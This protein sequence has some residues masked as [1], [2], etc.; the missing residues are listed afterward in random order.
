MIYDL[1]IQ[2]AHV[3]DP[4]T[5]RN[6]RYHILIQDGKIAKV[7][8]ATHADEQLPEAKQLI[9]AK[10]MIVTPGLIDLHVHVYEDK[11]PLGISADRIGVNQGVTTVVDAGSAG[12]TTFDEFIKIAIEPSTT[13]VLAWIN[14]SGSGLCQGLS[15][16]ANM[17]WLAVEET[18]KLVKKDA[19]VIGIKA[20]MSGS[21]VKESGIEPLRVA[22]K[23]A[24]ELELPTMV[25]IGNAPP[26]LTEVLPLLES[27]DVVTHAFHGKKGGIFTEMGELL[28]EAREALNRG[29]IFDVGHGTSSFSF[30][31][32]RHALKQGIKPKTI[33][34]DIYCHNVDGPVHS[35]AITMTKLVALG[36]SLE[37]V[38]EMSTAAPARILNQA[39]QLGTLQEGTIADL[40]IMKL[41]DEPIT[42][43]DS[44]KEEL[45][46]PQYIKPVMTVKT[47]KVFTCTC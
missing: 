12:A 44:E 26:K 43:I 29:V 28:P 47:G 6:G 46:T 31:T 38:I 33:S 20:R 5:N 25:H 22:K 23:L 13:E 24:N 7:L 4:A 27:G 2:H 8:H 10:E 17:E 14:I 19:R 15:E 11:T 45:V 42:L 41:V 3:I 21:V 30:A 36:I 32:M 18:K 35:M 37:E 40:T 16:L 9:D 39:N 1:I 34:T